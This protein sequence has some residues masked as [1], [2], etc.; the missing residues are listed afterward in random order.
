MGR[1]LN[2]KYFGNRNYGTNGN[3]TD[4]H[5]YDQYGATQ[6]DDGIGGEG[7][8]SVTLDALGSYTTRPTVTFPVPTIANGVTALGTITSEVLSAAV[9]GTQTRAYPVAAGAIGFSTGGSTF[10]ATVTSAALTSVVRASATTIGFATANANVAVSG[11][12]IHI[13]GASIT[14]TM[15]I[16]GVAIAAGQIYYTGAPSTTTSATLYAN[17]ADAVA[18]TNPLTIVAGTGTTG[19]TFTYGVTY[20]VVTALT[21]VARGSYEALVASGPAVNDTYGAGL[22]ITPT[23]RAKAVVVTQKGSGYS[24]A[25]TAG[26]LTFTQSVTAASVALTVDTGAVGSA[27]NQENAIIAYA[28]STDDSALVEVDIVR[29]V[30]TDRYRINFPGAGTLGNGAGIGRLKTTGLASTVINYVPSFRYETEMNIWAFDSAGGSYLVRKLTARKAVVVP[31]ACARLSKSAGAVFPLVN[32]VAQQ[33]PWKF[34]E[35]QANASAGY[36][37]IENA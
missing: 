19:A 16:G 12:S 31:A 5:A 2:K 15:T 33:V 10:T 3:E 27:T 8:A 34:F 22:T 20:G 32:G 4:N 23:Y 37:K 28:W 17:Y 6:G 26:S 36:V 35:G 11:N 13:T 25:L 21:P 7:V 24:S 1:P 29:Q 18:A 30:S 14:G 9:S